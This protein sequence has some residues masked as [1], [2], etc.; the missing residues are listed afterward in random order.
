MKVNLFP[1][2]WLFY[3]TLYIFFFY[4]FSS[5]HP[6]APFDSDDWLNS[7]I[8]R[9]SYPSLDYWNP[10]KVFPERFEPFVSIFSGYLIV[11]LVGGYIN[12]LIIGNAIVV[13]LFII[14]YLLSIQKYI[15]SRF[16]LSRLTT[17]TLII[18]FILFHFI[19]LRSTAECNEHLWY[20]NDS[21]CYYHYIIPNMLC[22]CLVL[23]LMQHDIRNVRSGRSIAALLV[24]TYL[25][26]CSNLYSVVILIAYIG[27][28][29]LL[30]LKSTKLTSYIYR[31]AP[32]LIVVILWGIIQL[33]ESSGKRAN[34]YGFLHK[35]L[36][37]SL[38]VTIYHFLTIRYNLWFLLIAFLALVGAKWHEYKRH[39][40]F[41][42]ID[43]HGKIILLSLCLSATYL[44]LLSSR[45][46]PG[47][48]QRGD[49]IFEYAFF[50]LLLLI[51]AFGYLFKHIKHLRLAAPLLLFFMLFQINTPGRTF[52]DVCDQY[53]PNLQGSILLDKEFVR[54]ILDAEAAGKDSIVINIPKYRDSENWPITTVGNQSQ[55]LGIALYKHNLT[56]RIVKTI[57]IPSYE[58]EE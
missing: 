5:I 51:I 57:F 1:S 37:H 22:A 48:I 39:R 34:T 12:G 26:L 31:N 38:A 25:A 18:I 56:K 17:Y 23:W 53:P 35:P 7:I 24:M 30:D 33:M 19:I 41:L 6:I 16:S 27:A 13:T 40:R 52:K 28:V 21:N 55:Y 47:Y 8:E 9:P 2:N 42:H 11:P 43:K 54:Q 46:N 45:V 58:L 14:L 20:S 36:I 32:Y 3:I 50:F 29:L 4:F 10:T 44:I 15:E 49:V